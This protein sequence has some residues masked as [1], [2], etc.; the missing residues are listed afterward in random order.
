M[1]GS[2]ELR[3]LSARKL[4][5]RLSGSFS[6]YFEIFQ[7]KTAVRMGISVTAFKRTDTV[8]RYIDR[9]RRIRDA[10]MPKARDLTEFQHHFSQFVFFIYIYSVKII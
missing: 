9:M 1:R 4:F 7:F 6:I 5:S 3:E 2:L 8:K 10:P